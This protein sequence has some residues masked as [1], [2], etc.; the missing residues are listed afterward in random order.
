MP[1]LEENIAYWNKQ[2]HWRYG[3]DEWSNW[4]GSP[5]AE[6]EAT[7]F[8][9]IADY[10]PAPR[11]VEIAP[12]Y[13]RW[14]EFLKDY[15][16]ELIGIDV[17]KRCVKACRRRFRGDRRLTFA[18]N[19]GRTLPK[20]DARSADLVFSFDSLVHVEWDVMRSYVHELARVLSDDGVAFV[21]HSNMAAYPA[22]EVGRKIPHWRSGSVSA[23]GVA[24]EAEPLGLSCFRQELL[25]WGDDNVY[26][27]D[28][29]TWIARNGSRHDQ[30]REVIVNDAFMQE[31]A[32]ALHSSP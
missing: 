23:E 8:P 13:G 4:W 31:P 29:F 28:A 30:K 21:H 32:R 14:T 18:V 5:E 1:D 2:F 22:E 20:V 3:G 12:G 11:I 26:L 15:S 19:D 25:H 27:S 7:V 24:F 9:R 17:A 10:L 6:W 16:D